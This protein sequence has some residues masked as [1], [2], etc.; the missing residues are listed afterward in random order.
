MV[1]IF[2]FARLKK[3][4]ISA[5]QY[6]LSA[7][8]DYNFAKHGNNLLHKFCEK[9]I[10]DSTCDVQSKERMKYE[11]ELTKELLAKEIDSFYSQNG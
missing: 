9:Y 6:G 10:D 7:G 1:K 11:L 5:V 8:A 3:A 4:Y 2:D